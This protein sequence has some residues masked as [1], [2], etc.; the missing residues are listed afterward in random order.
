M[1]FRRSQISVVLSALEYLD[2]N[3]ED[4]AKITYKELEEKLVDYETPNAVW[5]ELWADGSLPKPKIRN[6][7]HTKPISR[8]RFL[9]MIKQSYTVKEEIEMI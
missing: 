8:Q 9:A 6:I 1:G 3:F 4:V 7:V 5:V 2:L